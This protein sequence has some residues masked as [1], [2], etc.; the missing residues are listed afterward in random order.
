MPVRVC[1]CVVCVCVCACVSF[2]CLGFAFWLPL[3]FGWV[4][5]G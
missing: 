1:V 2:R 4:L 5:G 3:V